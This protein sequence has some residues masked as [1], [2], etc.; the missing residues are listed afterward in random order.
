MRNP[1]FEPFEQQKSKVIPFGGMLDVEARI[2]RNPPFE[3]FEQQ[4]SKV[5]QFGEMWSK[6]DWTR[7]YK[8]DKDSSDS[9]S[10]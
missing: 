5:I 2:M 1:P 10:D 4:K 6:Y 8:Q 9:D 7:M 3:P